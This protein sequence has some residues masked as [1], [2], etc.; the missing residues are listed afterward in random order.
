MVTFSLGEALPALSAAATCGV[1]LKHLAWIARHW[2]AMDG[3]G[4][5]GGV[6]RA[7]LG[8]ELGAGVGGSTETRGQRWGQLSL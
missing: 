5:L 4:A 3:S 7:N 6:S 2:G 1:D 8:R